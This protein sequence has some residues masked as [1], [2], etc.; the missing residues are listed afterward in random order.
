MVP[1]KVSY[2]QNT[3]S[4]HS[5]NWFFNMI[6]YRQETC[7]FTQPVALTPQSILRTI[8]I[9]YLKKG[10]IIATDKIKHSLSIFVIASNQES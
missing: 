2:L 7:V 10:I 6:S 1:L 9:A 5:G 4:F 3:Q 8:Y